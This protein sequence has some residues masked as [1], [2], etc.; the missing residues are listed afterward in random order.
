[1]TSLENLPVNWFDFTLIIVLAVGV[2][3]GRKH[4]LSQ[5]LIPL[6]QWLA[7]IFGAAFASGAVGEWLSQTTVFSLL[8]SRIAVYVTTLILIKVIFTLV[9]KSLGGK[10]TGSDIFGKAEYYVGM[11]AG[12]FRFICILIV[13]LAL[14]NARYFSPAELAAKDKY[15][16][17]MYGSNFFPALDEIQQGVF[18]KSLSGPQIKNHLDFLLI[19]P[20]APE[21][22]QLKRKDA[23]LP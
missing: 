1:M 9:K 14:L 3:R 12:F 11:V 20:T 4:G 2:L 19:K 16:K 18:Q 5:E 21:E 10:L 22:K 7:I 17:E 8:F 6:L 23:E 15:N 13:A